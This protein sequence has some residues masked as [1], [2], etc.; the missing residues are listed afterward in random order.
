M[1]V[2][3]PVPCQ[4]PKWNDSYGEGGALNEDF[5]T[6][7]LINTPCCN[8]DAFRPQTFTFGHEIYFGGNLRSC[9]DKLQEFIILREFDLP[10]T[11]Q[12]KSHRGLSAL[13]GLFCFVF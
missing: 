13:T 4:H 6:P 8:V 1:L 2:C 3:V 12:Y 11:K 7:T 5:Q 9:Y 10:R